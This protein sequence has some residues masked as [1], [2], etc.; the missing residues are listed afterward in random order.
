MRKKVHRSKRNFVPSVSVYVSRLCPILF[1][2]VSDFVP[3]C[4]RFCSRLCPILFPLVSVVVRALFLPQIR[5]H[6]D[7]VRSCVL[8]YVCL[9]DDSANRLNTS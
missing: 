8:M 6:L 7:C 2:F 5:F 1:P 9:A 4:V 3:V